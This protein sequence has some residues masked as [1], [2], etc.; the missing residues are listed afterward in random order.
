VDYSAGCGCAPPTFFINAYNSNLGF[1]DG[2]PTSEYF[3]D[4]AVDED[5][6]IYACGETEYLKGSAIIRKYNPL[7]AVLNP[8]IIFKGSYENSG[9]CYYSNYCEAICVDLLGNIYVHGAMDEMTGSL[10]VCPLVY[11]NAFNR[12]YN[13]NFILQPDIFSGNPEMAVDNELNFYTGGGAY[14]TRYPNGCW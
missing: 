1:V 13:S 6:N 5:G 3:H 4:L 10:M 9:A 2:I 12:K 14:L 8:D 11:G 7:F